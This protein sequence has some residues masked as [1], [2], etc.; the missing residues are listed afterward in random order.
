MTSRSVGIY[1]VSGGVSAGVG[2]GSSDNNNEAKKEKKTKLTVNYNVRPELTFVFS[3]WLQVTN[4]KSKYP[5]VTMY[6]DPSSLAVTTECLN[7][8]ITVTDPESL[9]AFNEKFGVLFA[10]RIQLGGRLSYTEAST[11]IGSVEVKDH[12]TKLK[13]AA[14]A[15]ISHSFAQASVTSSHEQQSREVKENSEQRST[16]SLA[17]EA[18]GGDTLLCNKLS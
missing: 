11:A 8:I 4:A 6:W 10:R 7:E 5:R 16:R 9:K 15:S 17:W 18:T 14:S 2:G 3:R 12:A 1:G 13:A